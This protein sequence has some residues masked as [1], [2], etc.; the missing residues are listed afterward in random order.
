MA[1]NLT[2]AKKAKNDEFYTQLS[3]IE[4]EVKHYKDQFR[5]KVVYLN[6][7]DAEWSNFWTYFKLNFQ[8]LGLK[9]LISTHYRK[10]SP[11]YKLVID[12]DIDINGDGVVN[13]KDLQKTNLKQNG[14]FRSSE[15]VEM[16]KECDIVVTNPPF[17]LFREFIAQLIENNKKF[18]ILGNTNSL[19]C[20]EI[21]SLIVYNQ[22]WLGVN[23]G[24]KTY[25]LPSDA[26]LKSSDFEKD[27]KKYAKLGNTSWYTNLQHNKRNEK[28]ILYKKYT[29]EEY[30]TY[31]NY[32]A[33]SVNKVKDIPVDYDGFMGVPITFLDKW[34]PEQFEIVWIA[35]GH[36]KTSIPKH[37]KDRVK[38]DEK[39]KSNYNT[40]G[41]GII[42]GR[43]LYHR[44]LI[45]KII[46]IK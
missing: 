12:R 5:D 36:T 3:D 43:Q 30:P 24:V 20:K 2:A 6:C 16:L 38:F 40:S 29:P 42:K 8:H 35:S 44:V 11:A 21:F 26:I 45:K 31:D 4:N 39:I 22:V 46:T 15:S 28:V 41:Y 27:G 34:N 13:E 1:N 9:K 37:V 17:S 23:N 10:D 18:L 32:D 25:E 7:D 14:D 19:T 33:I